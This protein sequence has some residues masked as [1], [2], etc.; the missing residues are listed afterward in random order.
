VFGDISIPGM[1][2]DMKLALEKGSRGLEK[3]GMGSQDSLNKVMI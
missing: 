2:K 1:D 3:L